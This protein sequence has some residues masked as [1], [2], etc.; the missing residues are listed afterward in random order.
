MLT[1]TRIESLQRA[2]SND[3]SGALSNLQERGSIRD[4]ESLIHMLDAILILLPR[5]FIN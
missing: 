4:T 2:L 1:R 5:P 3:I